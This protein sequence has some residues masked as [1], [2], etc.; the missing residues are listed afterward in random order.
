M[1]FTHII[2]LQF[3]ESEREKYLTQKNVLLVVEFQTLAREV[4]YG[5]RPH[6]PGLSAGYAPGMEDSGIPLRNSS[7]PLLRHQCR[8]ARR[9]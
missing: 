3:K 2:I 6:L 5:G 1:R 4:F 9:P 7:S 8:A